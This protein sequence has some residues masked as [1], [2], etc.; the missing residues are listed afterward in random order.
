[1]NDKNKKNVLVKNNNYL[2]YI[3]LIVLILCSCFI[4]YH[5]VVNSKPNKPTDD[6]QIDM[7]TILFDKE[8]LPRVDTSYAT[9]PLFDALLL[10]FTGKDLNSLGIQYTNTHQGYLKLI[11][12]ETDFLIVPQPSDDELKLAKDKGIELEFTKVV[13]EGFVFFVNKDNKI[14]NL[15]LQQV[16]KIYTGEITNWNQV[17]GDNQNI[18]AFQG[19]ENVESQTGLEK[20]VMKDNKIK[21]PTNTEKIDT[22]EQFIDKVADYDNGKNSIGYSYYYYSSTMYRNDN[23][24]YL[25]INGVAPEYK[26]I[27]DG[28]YPILTAYYIVTRKNEKN[29]KVEKLKDAILS[30]RGQEVVRGAGYVPVN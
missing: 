1:M 6:E 8:D 17:G 26:T 13:N 24:K 23:L 3:I 5:Y 16:Q 11:N 12:N 20:L 27:E 14:D 19:Q 4:L 9:Q 2:L 29:E 7:E 10:N 22:M 28:S 21:V 15:T 30:K 18:L 25:S